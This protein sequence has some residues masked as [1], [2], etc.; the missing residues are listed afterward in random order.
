MP[1]RVERR[2]Q[3]GHVVQHRRGCIG[4][5][6]HHR[7]DR[8]AGVRRQPLGD[9][10]AVDRVGE[11][12][13]DDLDVHPHLPRRLRPADPEAPGG[14]DQRLVAGREHVGDRR[15]PRRVAVADV[16]RHLAFGARHPLQVGED[17]LGHRDEVALVDVRRRPVHGVEHPVGND[18]RP[19]NGENVPPARQCHGKAPTDRR[20]HRAAPGR[21][22]AVPEARG[23]RRAPLPPEPALRPAHAPRFPLCRPGAR[24]LR[25][26]TTPAAGPLE[27]DVR[28]ALR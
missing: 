28:R 24:M 13:V 22:K 17:G 23:Q 2:P 3:G 25:P 18:R 26:A 1:G 7:L 11:A 20:H 10:G 15:F 12:E 5:H 21:A 9:A 8:M 16:D 6:R 19:G 14:K 27:T 4:L